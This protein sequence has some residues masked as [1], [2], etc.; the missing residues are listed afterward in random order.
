MWSSP[1]NNRSTLYEEDSWYIKTAHPYLDINGLEFILYHDCSKYQEIGWVIRPDEC[2]DMCKAEPPV[3]IK[4]LW[5]LVNVG[6]FN[7]S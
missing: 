2:C 1:A 7:G 6:C 3:T 4:T 5:V